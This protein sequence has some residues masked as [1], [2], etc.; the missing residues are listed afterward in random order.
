ML[1]FAFKKLK[2]KLSLEELQNFLRIRSEK[3]QFNLLHCAAASDSNEDSINFL[4][5]MI[6]K[7]LGKD[8][9]KKM[10]NE[11]TKENNFPLHCAIKSNTSEIFK[12]F[13][14]LYKNHFLKEEIEKLSKIKNFLELA[15]E[16][17]KEKNMREIVEKYFEGYD[18]KKFEDSFDENKTKEKKSS[19]WYKKIKLFKK[20]K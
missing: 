16:N 9:I 20:Q 13:A 17:Q 7:F 15:D 11:E 8:E 19:K 4:L 10:L 1:E 14:K 18:L 5:K 2:E 12:N 3:F 6:E